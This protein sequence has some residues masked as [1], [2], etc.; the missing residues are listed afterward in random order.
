MIHK[1]R[2]TDI[3]K[4]EVTMAISRKIRCEIKNWK[5]DWRKNSKH[6]KKEV[7]PLK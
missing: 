7:K 1:V 6:D 2:T 3:K 4:Y 5:M